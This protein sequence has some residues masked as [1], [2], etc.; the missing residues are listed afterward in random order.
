MTVRAPAQA[1]HPLR[2]LG[3]DEIRLAKALLVDHGLVGEH[4]RFAYLGLEEPPKAEVLAFRE[5]DPVDRR[6]RAILLDTAT[7]GATDV[8]ASLTRGTVDASAEIDTGR[9]GQPPIML[10]DLVAVDQIVKADPGWR[11]AMARRG[12]T[13][14]DLVRPCPL[15][16]GAFGI[17]GEAGRRML[18]VLSFVQHHEKDHPWA[19]P[20]DGLVAYVDLIERRVR[21][22]VDTEVL[23]IPEEE[24]NFDDP[25]QAG[26]ARTSLKPIH[27]TQPEGPSFSLDGE[28]VTWEGW[29]LRVG[30]DAREGLTLHQVSLQ[31][32]PVCYRASIAEMM[33]PYADPGPARFWQNYFDAG[34]YLLGQQVVSLTL[35]CDCLGEIRYLDAVLPTGDGEPLEVPN[36]I[37]LHEE[38]TGVAWRHNDLFTGSSETRRMRRLVVSS[39]VAIGNYD[40]GFF[41]YLYL[42]GRIEL[43]VKA[44]G[45]V[46]TS[47]YVEGSRWAT[48]VAPGL[49]APYHQHLFSAR[50]DMT[51]DGVGN[52]V[53]EVELERVPVGPGNQHG[54]AFTRK[55]TRL[56]RESEAARVADP[57]VGRTWQVVNPARTNRL[58]QPVAYALD[59][60]PA[61]LLAA[62][63]GAAIAGRAAFA[64]RHLWVTRYDPAERYAAGDLPNQHPGGAG[65]PAYAAADR[66]LD[67]Q[68]IVLWHTF[69]M[70]HFPRPEDWPV[71]PVA[72][73]G[74]TLRPVGFFDRN[75]VLDLPG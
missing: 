70:L 35:G 75:P 1:A 42:D 10:E 4:T 60:Q 9:D 31:D 34:E 62:D 13:D 50:L 5:G 46:F 28:V 12:V 18:R 49:G 73:C 45:V 65:L 63:A 25:A 6:V 24:G 52:A 37:C 56:A 44:T 33:V 41:W 71:M 69:G 39:F 11:A 67:G 3:A 30:F 48:Q 15:S 59:P 43:E 47:A 74:F 64:T 17:E 8:V 23:P 14:L 7:G 2:R 61:P 21:H 36:A 58:G 29:R 26:P 20:V 51:V 55:V 19:H 66:D 38:D 72:T 57:A 22:L 16:A 54:N 53:D 40:Y 27:V 32:R 68:D